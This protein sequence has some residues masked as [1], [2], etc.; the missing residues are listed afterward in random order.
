MIFLFLSIL[1]CDLEFPVFKQGDGKLYE[2]GIELTE[3]ENDSSETGQ[4]EEQEEETGGE[5]NEE[6]QNDDDGSENTN[7]TTEDE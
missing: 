3:P 5:Q 2:R 7:G 4:Q 1:G 6:E